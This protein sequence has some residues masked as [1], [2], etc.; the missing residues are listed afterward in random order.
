MDLFQGAVIGQCRRWRD[1]SRSLG[2]HCHRGSHAQKS[3]LPPGPEARLFDGYRS[4][5]N[6]KLS[7]EILNVNQAQLS[8]DTMGQGAGIGQNAEHAVLPYRHSINGTRRRSPRM[9]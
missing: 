1:S 3:I 4:L 6:A 9:P 7:F 2:L 5:F 8:R